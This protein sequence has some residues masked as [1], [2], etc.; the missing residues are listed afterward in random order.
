MHIFKLPK[1]NLFEKHS[2]VFSV[3]DCSHFS[4]KQ[5][6]H[7]SLAFLFSPSYFSQV[8]FSNTLTPSTTLT[9]ILL[10]NH[11]DS[12]QRNGKRGPSLGV[13]I[14]T[15]TA[16]I[17][18]NKEGFV[19]MCVCAWW[20]WLGVGGK[21]CWVNEIPLGMKSTLLSCFRGLGRCVRGKICTC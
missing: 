1:Y 15:P 12:Q 21:L 7:L 13:N 17:I 4:K 19:R 14:L 20:R 2:S 16:H 5:E 11:G 9:L 3:C 8:H 18:A 10:C 6:K